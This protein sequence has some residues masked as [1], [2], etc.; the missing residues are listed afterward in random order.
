MVGTY[1]FL[2]K[3]YNETFILLIIFVNKGPFF[4]TCYAFIQLK[5]NPGWSEWNKYT[6]RWKNI[7]NDLRE[8]RRERLHTPSASMKQNLSMMSCDKGNDF[9]QGGRGS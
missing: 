9:Y 1:L 7:L 8:R 6:N 5:V 3:K 2:K 4:G